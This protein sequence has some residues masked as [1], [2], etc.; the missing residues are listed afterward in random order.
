M[1]NSIK[2]LQQ[3]WKLF[4]PRFSQLH[5]F[6]FRR[7]RDRESEI[8]WWRWHTTEETRKRSSSR[9]FGK[10]L[11]LSYWEHFRCHQQ[12][13]LPHSALFCFNNGVKSTLD[14]M[15]LYTTRFSHLASF[16][17]CILTGLFLPSVAAFIVATNRSLLA[18]CASSGQQWISSP[19]TL[20]L[21]P[22][23]W[24][25]CSISI[26]NHFTILSQVGTYL[27]NV[28]LLLK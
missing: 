8:W 27:L 3:R 14:E 5:Q 20:K 10:T 19:H 2:H 4:A 28:S 6:G 15:Q 9:M 1:L 13:P 12:H 11:L 26:K 7:E 23:F 18:G 16:R 17:T 25:I 21:F 24:R 22:G